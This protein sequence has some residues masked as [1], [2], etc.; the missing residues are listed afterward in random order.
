MIR[1]ACGNCGL[2]SNHN[3]QP[4]SNFKPFWPLERSPSVPP[5][6]TWFRFGGAESAAVK[7]EHKPNK[8]SPHGSRLRL[9]KLHMRATVRLVSRRRS[10]NELRPPSFALRNLSVP[11]CQIKAPLERSLNVPPRVTWFR[12]GWPEC[13]AWMLEHQRNE[14]CPHGSRLRLGRLHMRARFYC[15]QYLLSSFKKYNVPFDFAT[16][17]Q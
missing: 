5:R 12:F 15:F 7:L 13:A 2:S 9:G 11:V 16:C 4:C 6:V 1:R 17:G 8:K 3:G 14:K 10:I